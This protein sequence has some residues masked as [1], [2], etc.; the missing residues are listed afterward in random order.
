MTYLFH[1]EEKIRRKH[2]SRAE[3]IPLL[4]P[5]LLCRVLEHLGFPVERYRETRRVC[6]A[7][8]TVEKWKIVFRAPHLPVDPPVEADP[9]RDPP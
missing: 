5:W 8:F 6:K 4:F 3:T 9:K 7:T 1:F 2:L